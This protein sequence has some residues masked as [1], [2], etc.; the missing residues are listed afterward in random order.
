MSHKKAKAIRKAMFLRG[1]PVTAQGYT[2]NRSAG[3]I[4]ASR[5]RRIYRALKSHPLQEALL[6]I[7]KLKL[8]KAAI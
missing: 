2:I 4:Y 1:I 3:M 5:E 6:I 7:L 8:P